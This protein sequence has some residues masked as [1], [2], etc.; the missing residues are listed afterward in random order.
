MVLKYCLDEVLGPY[1]SKS[2]VN[3]PTLEVTTMLKVSHGS[4]MLR[5]KEGIKTHLKVVFF[6]L[7]EVP[8]VQIE[9]ADAAAHSNV[10]PIGVKG[11][12]VDHNRA[13][14]LLD[15]CGN[16]IEEI[17]QRAELSEGN[18]L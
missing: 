17:V 11:R 1:S 8:A 16:G 6:H 4:C 14:T 3:Y 9:H 2:D 13:E 10:V 7:V 15:L 12:K 5:C 18:R